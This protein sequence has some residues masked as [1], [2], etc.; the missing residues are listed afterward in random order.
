MKIS[1]LFYGIVKETPIDLRNGTFS[2]LASVWMSYS[3]TLSID[4]SFMITSTVPVEINGVS[5]NLKSSE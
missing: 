4:T 2:P 5:T 1:R 3:K